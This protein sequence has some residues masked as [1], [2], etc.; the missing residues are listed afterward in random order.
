MPVWARCK[1][2]N[3]HAAHL[4]FSM[5]A[6][7]VP[8]AKPGAGARETVMALPRTPDRVQ[9]GSARGIATVARGVLTPGGLTSRF[10]GLGGSA[11]PV[12]QPMQS[13]C[14]VTN[15]RLG[16]MSKTR[17]SDGTLDVSDESL[18][19]EYA[20]G[21]VEAFE[22]L[23]RRYE[24]TA[25]AFF[26]KRV[27]SQDQARD[28]YQELF[29]RVHRG[30]H[31]YDPR[32]P[33]TPWFFQIA[34]RLLV[35]DF[36]RAFRHHETLLGNVLDSAAGGEDSLPI[37]CDLE[38]MMSGLSAEEQYVLRSAKLT[39]DGYR[40]IAADLGKSVDAIKK[41]ASRAMEKLRHCA[42]RGVV[43]PARG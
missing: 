35:D 40:E 14:S 5:Y 42:G 22:E 17:C 19:A 3:S 4:P 13:G 23:F 2:T 16:R 39:G 15:A 30:R 29:L 41:I 31:A 18:M 43:V 24:Q 38:Q 25:Y 11:L 9:A 26:V 1:P 33:F 34:H 21:R 28:L 6:C 7:A 8:V 36:R 10:V 12:V 27:G 37:R 32:R 20:A